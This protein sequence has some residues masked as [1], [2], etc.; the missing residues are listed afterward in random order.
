MNTITAPTEEQPT[1]TLM[2]ALAILNKTPQ[3]ER[4]NAQ[5]MVFSTICGVLEDRYSL[6]DT[7]DEIYL[8]G[9]EKVS[10]FEAMEI[11]VAMVAE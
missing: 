8:G 2:G 6:S 11:A 4:T 10:Y 3:A 5:R 1:P 9:D 7:L